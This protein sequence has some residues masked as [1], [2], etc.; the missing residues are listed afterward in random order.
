MFN[1]LNLGFEGYRKIAIKD[2]RNARLL[3]RALENTYFEVLSE[4]HRPVSGDK[5]DID[6]PEH[7]L[8]GLP[9]VS[10]R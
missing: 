9:V 4:V 7:Y 5:H 3:S 1:F 8:P 2:L 10:F 6:D